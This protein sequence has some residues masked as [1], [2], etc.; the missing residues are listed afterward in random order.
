LK[1]AALLDVTTA[2]VVEDSEAGIASGRAAGFDV[3]EVPEARSMP[4]I[5]RRHLALREAPANA[6]E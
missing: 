4:A 2:L 1:A 5:L 6:R 3:L